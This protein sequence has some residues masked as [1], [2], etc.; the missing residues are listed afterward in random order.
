LSPASTKKNSVPA[1]VAQPT[2]CEVPPESAD[3]GVTIDVVTRG[4]DVPC[5][6]WIGLYKQ[7]QKRVGE[8]AANDQIAQLFQMAAVD[9]VDVSGPVMISD[10][11]RPRPLYVYLVAPPARKGSDTQQWV[12]AA[13]R[14]V[15]SWTPEY[16]GFYLAPELLD[17]EASG[18]ILFELISRYVELHQTRHF[19]L[20]VGHL[21]YHRAL[22]FAHFLKGELE[23][24]Q[25]KTRI[26]H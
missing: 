5:D 20:L 3:K 23:R 21:G 22:N 18:E 25:I 7:G 26:L 19:C 8:V 11:L 2:S 10:T 16:V 13:M 6:F 4:D 15:Q 1:P 24:T 14:N 9:G 17:M 12:Q